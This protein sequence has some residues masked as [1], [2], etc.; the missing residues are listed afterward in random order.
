MAAV[1]RKRIGDG[2]GG[3]TGDG[4]DAALKFG[5][6]LHGA[7][8]RVA[9]QARIDGHG[10]DAGGA[11]ADIN[12]GGAAKA[13]E[14]ESGD[15]E[16]NEGHGYLR[17]DEEVAQ[18]PEAAGAREDVFAFER[19]GGKSP[20]GGPGGEQ[21]EKNTGDETEREREGEN[22]GVDADVEI[23]GDGNG[24]T[25]GGE[26]VGGPEG[27][28]NAECTAEKRKKNGFG[29]D[30]AKKLRARGTESNADGHFV[31]ASGS[32][33]EEKIGDVGAGDEKNEKDDDH[34]GGEEKQDGGFIAGRERAGLF[35]TEAEIFVGIGMGLRETL[36]EKIEFGGGFG[37]GDA[38]LEARGNGDPMIIAL[39]EMSGVGK[40]LIDVADGNP[41]LRVEDEDRCRGSREGQRR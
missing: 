7:F 37:L 25:K 40:E 27:N 11:E 16:K 22:F 28:E 3:D 17:D 31:L 21:A 32:L 5:E 26:A 8:G 13:A 9:V 6:E 2:G 35:E 29:E 38:G 18:S 23:D 34:E 36:G 12:V 33:R 10:E 39:V 14:A 15:A 1:K 20:G 24:K 30:L 4:G 41:E 19:G